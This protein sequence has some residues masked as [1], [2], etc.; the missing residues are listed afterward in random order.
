MLEPAIVPPEILE[1]IIITLCDIDRR[2]N[3][4]LLTLSRSFY[5]TL[6]S[7]LHQHV[8]LIETNQIQSF[9]NT[10]DRGA[11]SVSAV[12]SISLE[13][14]KASRDACL[15]DWPD[16]VEEEVKAW[17]GIMRVASVLIRHNLKSMA[18]ANTAAKHIVDEIDSEGSLVSPVDRYFPAPVTLDVLAVTGCDIDADAYLNRIKARVYRIYGCRHAFAGGVYVDRLRHELEPERVEIMIGGFYDNDPLRTVMHLSRIFSFPDN[19][20]L[21]AHCLIPDITLFVR[22]SLGRREE[23]R[24]LVD[25]MQS[26]PRSCIARQV[27]VLD[28]YPRGHTQLSAE[29]RDWS[30]AGWKDSPSVDPSRDDSEA[31]DGKPWCECDDSTIREMEEW[32]DAGTPPPTQFEINFRD[33]EASIQASIPLS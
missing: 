22:A 9:V 21:S 16:Q 12:Q 29:Q 19:K 2:Q 33:R 15:A 27:V 23:F 5:S 31:S 1:K 28:W 25:L 20:S 32:D 4:A 6:R 14:R 30:D 7:R 24:S 3:H 17:F 11:V 13:D 18:I 26:D 10:F 8:H